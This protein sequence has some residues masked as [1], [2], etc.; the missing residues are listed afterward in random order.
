MVSKS[1]LWGLGRAKRLPDGPGGAPNGSKWTPARPAA[2]IQPSLMYGWS[3]VKFRGKG[4]Q[5]NWYP[6]TKGAN[7]HGI[8]PTHLPLTFEPGHETLRRTQ[9]PPNDS[10]WHPAAKLQASS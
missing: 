9:R 10:R 2:R 6:P 7:M 5:S 3:G 8:V 4:A 1:C